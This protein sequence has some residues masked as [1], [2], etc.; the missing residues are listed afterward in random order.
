MYSS[1]TAVE[2]ANT[3]LETNRCFGGEGL[4]ARVN[5][6]SFVGD[7]NDVKGLGSSVAICNLQRFP[8]TNPSLFSGTHFLTYY[9][10]ILQRM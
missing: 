4:L 8:T 6:V 1:V 7:E 2:V 9:F 10:S 5:E 3:S